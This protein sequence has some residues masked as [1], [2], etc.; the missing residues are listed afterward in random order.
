M[1]NGLNLYL[2]FDVLYCEALQVDKNAA[3]LQ[4]GQKIRVQ[5]KT[6]KLLHE[7]EMVS[8]GIGSVGEEGGEVSVGRSALNVKNSRARE[9]GSRDIAGG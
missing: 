6:F 5:R 1:Y 3:R 8:G 4:Q 9:S 2:T 7:N